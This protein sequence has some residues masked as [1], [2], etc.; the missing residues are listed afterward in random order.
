MMVGSLP[1]ADLILAYIFF[2]FW[3]QV[4]E[5]FASMS[6]SLNQNSDEIDKV[7]QALGGRCASLY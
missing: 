1:F 7:R 3:T 5:F 2:G 4:T 6:S